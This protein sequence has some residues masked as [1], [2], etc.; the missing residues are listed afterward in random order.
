MQF[1]AA[2]GKNTAFQ[3]SAYSYDVVQIIVRAVQE[4][5]AIAWPEIAA[6]ESSPSDTVPPLVAK[7]RL[8]RTGDLQ[9]S[10]A[11]RVKGKGKARDVSQ[12]SEEEWGM[13]GRG[14]GK[15]KAR[16]VSGEGETDVD[17]TDGGRIKEEPDDADDR[18][19]C[20]V[21]LL[22]FTVQVLMPPGYLKVQTEIHCA[23]K[24]T[25]EGE[26]AS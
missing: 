13:R 24:I 16:E 8:S 25:S 14:K 2:M 6:L 4:D 21:S 26:N 1:C 10:K 5:E 23:T 18:E 17:D 20:H 7:R 12:D 3:P 9:E 19:V 11:K 15:G 22:S